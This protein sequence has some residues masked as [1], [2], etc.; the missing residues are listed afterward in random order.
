MTNVEVGRE[1][2]RGIGTGREAHFTSGKP[3]VWDLY[4][5]QMSKF[6]KKKREGFSQ[7]TTHT[8]K[9]SKCGCRG[10]KSQ[11]YRSRNVNEEWIAIDTH[12]LQKRISAHL[13]WGALSPSHEAPHTQRNEPCVQEH[14]NCCNGH[15][16]KFKTKQDAD[17]VPYRVTWS[18]FES[19]LNVSQ[20]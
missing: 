10:S 7:A 14:S 8:G 4:I 17:S 3:V 13:S 1:S 2:F 20:I 9:V 15:C 5:W 6:W 11:T 16:Y 18:Y 19:V 12:R